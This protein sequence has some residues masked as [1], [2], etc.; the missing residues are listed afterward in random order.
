VDDISTSIKTIHR[1]I[2]LISELHDASLVSINEQQWKQNSAQL[3]QFVKDTSSM[4]NYIKNRI[5]TLEN[6]NAKHPKNSDLNI[7]RAQVRTIYSWHNINS[8]HV[9]YMYI[10]RLLESKRNSSLVFNVTKM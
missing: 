8:K 4:N 7:R 2:D 3:S 6:S 10:Y 1:Q 5:Q 9:M